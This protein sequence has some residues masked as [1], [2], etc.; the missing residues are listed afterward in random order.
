MAATKIGSKAIRRVVE[1][2]ADGG[3]VADADES[4]REGVTVGQGSEV[5]I[6]VGALEKVATIS[7]SATIR[8]RIRVGAAT[9]PLS[10]TSPAGADAY[11]SGDTVGSTNCESDGIR[12]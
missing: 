9:V 10:R 3:I 2:P 7:L 12:S 8:L 1:R 5:A 11:V 6:V 4:A